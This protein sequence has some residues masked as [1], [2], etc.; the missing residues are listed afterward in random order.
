M[1]GEGTATPEASHAA[2]H[3]MRHTGGVIGPECANGAPVPMSLQPLGAASKRDAMCVPFALETIVVLSARTPCRMH[4]C[5]PGSK[6]VK[7]KR[8]HCATELLGILTRSGESSCVLR[9]RPQPNP[10]STAQPWI[11]S[12]TLDPLECVHIP[13]THEL[14]RHVETRKTWRGRLQATSPVTPARAMGNP[15]T[16]VRASGPLKG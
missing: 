12:L 2:S 11:S 4:L 15:C 3:W 1:G 6:L 7:L 5:E 16:H 13:S 8:N 10:G 9:S 14:L